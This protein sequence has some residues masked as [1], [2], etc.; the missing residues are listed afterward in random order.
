MKTAW[1]FG[2]SSNFS[3]QI[4]SEL[5]NQHYDTTG[6]GRSNVDYSDFD[7]FIQG[8]QAPNV[9][10]LNA[11]VEE[12]ISLIIDIFNY[13]DVKLKD[14]D[15]MFLAYTPIF[16]FF[17]KLLKWIESKNKTDSVCSI[18]SSIT[19]HPQIENKYIMYA[20]LRSMLQQVVFS[21][22]N[23]V[24]NAFCVSPN[25][26]D[27]NN[28]ESYAKAVVELLSNKLVNRKIINLNEY[29]R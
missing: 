17:V 14:L 29:I 18:S 25:Y 21:A 5:K 2:Q 4:I 11:N 20:V 8:K 28:S 7:T 3:K 12:K 22:S 6:F 23:S 16:L 24:S 19:Q 26:L 15:E 10:I 9:L 27:T 1:L 13:N